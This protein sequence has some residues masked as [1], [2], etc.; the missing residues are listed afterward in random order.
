MGVLKDFRVFITQGNVIFLAVAI[1][2][3]LAFT[4]VVTAFISDIITPLLGI[5]GHVDF[6]TL[7][8]T[9]N[10]STFYYG[11][12]INALIAFLTIAFVVY[13][14][15]VRPI[16]KS[17][18]RRAARKKKISTEVTTK[19]CQYCIST[20]PIKATKCPFCTSVL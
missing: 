20:I 10:G 4:A 8:F 19:I 7:T 12:F 9:I 11:A 6:S 17:E 15:L 18:E 14:V 1:I 3:G 13:M 2:I 5:P 16:S